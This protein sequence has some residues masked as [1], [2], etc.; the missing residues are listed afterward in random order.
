MSGNFLPRIYPAYVQ[1]NCVDLA[2]HGGG[3]AAVGGAAIPDDDEDE[4][5]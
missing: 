4:D 3:A 5:M 1:L 2:G